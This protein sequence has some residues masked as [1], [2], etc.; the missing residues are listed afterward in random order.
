[1][2]GNARGIWV[3]IA[4]I[5]RSDQDCITTRPFGYLG[6][7]TS[8]CIC[9]L[10]SIQHNIQKEA[11]PEPSASLSFFPLMADQT[12]LSAGQSRFLRDSASHIQHPTPPLAGLRIEPRYQRGKIHPPTAAQNHSAHSR[13][14]GGPVHL[15]PLLHRVAPANRCADRS[16]GAW[17]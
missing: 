4:L 17:C 13:F 7:E 5:A 16:N 12:P 1:M 10:A 8:R 6:L 11:C 3:W 2:L 9:T 15:H 14:R